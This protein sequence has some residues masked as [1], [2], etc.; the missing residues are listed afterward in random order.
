LPADEVGD[1]FSMLRFE[2]KVKLAELPQ[3]VLETVV[4]TIN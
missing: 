3:D 4:G 2:H 1:L